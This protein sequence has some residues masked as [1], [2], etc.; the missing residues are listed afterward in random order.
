MKKH[1][2]KMPMEV[3]LDSLERIKDQTFR[4]YDATT[5]REKLSKYDLLKLSNKNNELSIRTE[6]THKMIVNSLEEEY[7]KSIK[8]LLAIVVS[9]MSYLTILVSPYLGA[10]SLLVVA[11]TVSRKLK[12]AKEG[13]TAT[14]ALESKEKVDDLTSEIETLLLKNKDLIDSLLRESTDEDKF[15][16][17]IDSKQK[18]EKRKLEVEKRIEEIS[19]L[20]RNEVTEEKPMTLKIHK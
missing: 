3:G 1:I 4:I 10:L 17:Y 16:K 19:S 6:N 9:C 8:E 5:S 14:K 7:T 20:E 2:S 18:E 15:K 12:S 11:A 13:K